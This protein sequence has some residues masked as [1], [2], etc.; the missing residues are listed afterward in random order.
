[1]QH[2]QQQQR[3]R[4]AQRGG[5]RSLRFLRRDGRDVGDVVGTPTAGGGDGDD[6]ADMGMG[7]GL[8]R[9]REG[10]REAVASPR[11]E[12]EMGLESS[13]VDSMLGFTG[14]DLGVD[15][16]GDI[17]EGDEA[18]GSEGSEEFEGEEL[19]EEEAEFEEEEEEEGEGLEEEEEIDED[20]EEM[21]AEGEDGIEQSPSRFLSVN[22]SRCDYIT[23]TFQRKQKPQS[24]LT[25]A[26]YPPSPPG[27]SQPTNQAAASPR[28]AILLPCNTG[29]LTVPNL[30]H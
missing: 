8:R 14:E 12:M 6:V 15:L 29:N 4:Q 24:L 17:P 7:R 10:V 5:G 21:D 23:N 27:P 26:K 13:V 11:L 18:L 19:D 20:G 30:I 22:I 28:S 25:S 9:G 3:E 2:Q 1:M 16:D